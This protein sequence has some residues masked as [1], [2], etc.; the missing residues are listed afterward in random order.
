MS[1]FLGRKSR[2]PDFSDS[3][4][5]PSL[6]GVPKSALPGIEGHA[7]K[8]RSIYRV[9]GH[10]HLWKYPKK[11]IWHLRNYSGHAVMLTAAANFSSGKIAANYSRAPCMSA[12]NVTPFKNVP[13]RHLVV[14]VRICLRGEAT[15]SARGGRRSFVLLE[16]N[17]RRFTRFPLSLDSRSHF[18]VTDFP[19]SF[20]NDHIM[21]V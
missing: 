11:T 19:F 6:R 15:L 12:R 17:F 5:R 14:T 1:G 21:Y 13:Q 4:R 2:P 20:D 7:I 9:F 8:I 10:D 16:R 3:R 18:P